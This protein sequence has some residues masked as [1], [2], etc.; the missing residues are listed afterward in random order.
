M[1]V[2]KNKRICKSILR[3]YFDNDINQKLQS[4]IEFFQKQKAIYSP[5]PKTKIIKKTKKKKLA[6][7]LVKYNQERSRIKF[8]NKEIANQSAYSCLEG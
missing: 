5:K 3:K 6:R 1:T 7:G 2:C 4:Y 8:L